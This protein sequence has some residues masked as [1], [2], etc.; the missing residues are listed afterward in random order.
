MNTKVKPVEK[1]K[2][3]PKIPP[4]RFREDAEKGVIDETGDTGDMEDVLS[5]KSAHVA[6][7]DNY[8]RMV[9]GG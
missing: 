9:G 3:K 7:K 5:E 2:V 1:A 4:L 8:K 6:R